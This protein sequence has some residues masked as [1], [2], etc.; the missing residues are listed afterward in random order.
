MR[1]PTPAGEL[2][3]PGNVLQKL[4]LAVA[5]DA[6]PIHCAANAGKANQGRKPGSIKHFNDTEPRESA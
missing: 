4:I 2:R 3:Q 6:L 5:P 1:F